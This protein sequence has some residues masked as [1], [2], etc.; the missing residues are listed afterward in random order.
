MS[1][2]LCFAPWGIHGPP[3]LLCWDQAPPR[4][5]HRVPGGEETPGRAAWADSSPRGVTNSAKMHSCVSACLEGYIKLICKI[6]SFEGSPD[7]PQLFSPPL[8]Q[9]LGLIPAAPNKP[10]PTNP[11]TPKPSQHS[12]EPCQGCSCGEKAKTKRE[13][14]TPNPENHDKNPGEET[15]ASKTTA[16]ALVPHQKDHSD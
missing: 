2:V 4:W 13:Q 1:F 3:A 7:L 9:H 15:G 10:E 5:E 14:T 6:L 11:K 16:A 8:A 12:P